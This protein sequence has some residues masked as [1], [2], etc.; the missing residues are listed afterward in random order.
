MTIGTY[1]RRLSQ[2]PGIEALLGEPLVHLRLGQSPTS[3]RV[4]ALAGWGF[5]P[6]TNRPRAIAAQYEL[7]FIGLEDGFLRSYGTGPG[8]PTLSLVVDDSGIYYAAGRPSRLENLLASDSNLLTGPGVGYSQ[9]RE[10]I[11]A[12]GLSKYNLA[13][14]IRSLP[15]PRHGPK[16]LVV[17]QTMG[18]TSIEFG[19]AKPETFEEMLQCARDENPGA[20]IYVKTHPEVSQ[21]S[22]NGYLSATIEDSRTILLRD[23]I[24]PAS[25]F[26]QVDHVY[27]V[28]SQMGFEA[29]L[30]GLPVT[31]FGI[32]WY[33]GWGATKDRLK[34]ERRKRE[35]DT[36][37]LFAAA[38]LH[39]TSYLDPETLQPG[40]IFQVI[41][42]LDLQRRMQ[43]A[44]TGRSIAIGYRRW[45]A[46]NV[47]PFLGPD[48][49]RVHFVP[50][51][52]AAVALAPTSEDRL[53]VW[54]SSPSP[55]TTEL[56]KKS[57][58]ALLRMEDGFVRSVGLGS[59]FVPPHALVLDAQGL[60]FDAR[61]TH[62]LEAL[63]NSQKFTSR[64][65]ERAKR[66]Q[67][68]IVENDLTKYNIEPSRLP[69]WKHCDRH[70][71]LV[72][73]QVEDDASIRY[74]CGAVHDNLTLLKSAR[75]ARPDSY[76]VYK[77]HPDVAVQN[78]KGKVHANDAL[79]YADHIETQVSITSCLQACHEVHTMTSLSGF[80]ALLRGKAVVVYGTPF[81]SGW[82]LTQD[83]MNVQRRN[84][85]LSLDELIAGVM[86]HYPIYWDWTLN[87]YTT[88]EASL[89]RIIAQ[90]SAVIAAGGLHTVRKN[91][92]QRQL[93]KARLWAK[94]GFV[95]KR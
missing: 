2:L 39:Y 60:Y 85:K 40:S 93:H 23:P 45:K 92:F 64:D 46:A 8:Y 75:Q 9:A 68:L 49:K 18:D 38:Y 69:N 22:K 5:R 47:R 95:L 19:L 44:M 81:Y 37:E 58:A 21:G 72:P 34:S 11:V 61:Q 80:D 13:P 30:H 12:K 84:R 91:Y 32:P 78:R 14:D 63:L 28:T 10:Q 24:A 83:M 89:R 3:K 16:I 56:A 52:K 86:L 36:D 25:L 65:H 15:G 88:C 17:D 77:P 82:G 73:G 70:V 74:G 94:A 53:I 62:E 67:Q 43:R 7:P 6:S 57:G 27:V 1:S 48:P 4:S 79:R 29:M 90:R 51:A 87:G 66:V 33:A 20:T 31:C 50:H 35:R 26:S 54:G 42:W 55:A 76:I 59:D 41:E 71:V